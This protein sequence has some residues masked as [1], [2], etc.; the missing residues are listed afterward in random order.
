MK[1]LD[2]L[3]MKRRDFLTRVM[4]AC[5]IGCLGICDPTNLA[6]LGAEALPCQEKHKFDED[7]PVPLTLRQYMSRQ[8]RSGGQVLKAIEG[9]IGE[10]ELLR[11]LSDYSIG[12][13]EAQGQGSAEQYPDRDFFSYNERFRT[14]QM[15]S[16][17]TYEIVEDSEEAFEINVTECVLVEPMLELD[18][19][20]IGNAWLCDGDYGHAQG[21]NPKIRL[22]RD[23]TLMLGDS[24]CN[25]RYEWVE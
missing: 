5:A 14:G 10:D 25:H 23:K 24:C 15:Q 22:I 17:I 12:R 3:S 9:E 21:F 7:F 2:S 19:G 18:A 20:K 1:Q 8:L 11:I 6:A 16:M 4:P 13:G